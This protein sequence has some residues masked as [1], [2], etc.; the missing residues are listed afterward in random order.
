MKAQRHVNTLFK[1]ESI[2]TRILRLF[3]SIKKKG[4]LKTFKSVFLSQK[5]FRLKIN[6]HAYTYTQKPSID[7]NDSKNNY[8]RQS[9]MDEW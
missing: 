2:V 8:L 7:Q 5:S 1:Q 4:R 9:S 6:R 3:D